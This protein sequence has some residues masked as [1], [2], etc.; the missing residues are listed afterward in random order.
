[1]RKR[2]KAKKKVKGKYIFIPILIVL[3]FVLLN[4]LF[5]NIKFL[6]PRQIVITNAFKSNNYSYDSKENNS[7]YEDVY[8]YIKENIFNTPV[9]ILKSEL[10]FKE[11]NKETITFLY[12]ESKK[13]RVYI[14]NSHQGETYSMKYLE[15]YNIVPDVL[16]ASNM[17]KDKLDS[18]GI[19]TVVEESD[20]LAYMKENNLN[21]SGS[22]I[23]SKHFL[24]KAIKEYPNIELFI[25]LHRD[26]A[27]HNATYA[28]IDGKDCAKVLFVI[29]L[30]NPNYQANLS[31]VTEINNILLDKY[32]QLTR[33]IMKKE[34]AGVDGVYNQDL[35]S[36]VILIEIGGNENNI[37]EVNN[38]LDIVASVIGEYLNEKEKE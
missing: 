15:V 3:V 21:H 22:Y 36:N 24:T 12:G 6:V 2:F 10:N 4:I 38:T 29:G 31:V 32:P 30:E 14:Y 28:K 5:D 27:T 1:M 23:A 25:D 11:S 16:M 35:N 20:I 13:N 7:I 18:I 8:E 26:A 37:E 33:G 34:G 9:N 17:L 19:N